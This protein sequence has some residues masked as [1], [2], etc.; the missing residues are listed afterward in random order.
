FKRQ[1]VSTVV[2]HLPFGTGKHAC[3]GRFFAVTEL[4]AMMA[5]LVMNYDVKAE[6]EGVRPP[7]NILVYE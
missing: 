6:V 4:K 2:D 3:P 5:H 1:M 7:D